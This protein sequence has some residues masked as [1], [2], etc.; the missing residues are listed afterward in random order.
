MAPS[1][2]VLMRFFV[3][4]VDETIVEQKM[5]SEEKEREGERERERGGGEKARTAG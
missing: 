4:M 5:L 2:A 1:A 3:W